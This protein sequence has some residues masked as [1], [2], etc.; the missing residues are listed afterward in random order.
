M[1]ILSKQQEK[2]RLTLIL[3]MRLQKNTLFM[4]FPMSKKVWAHGQSVILP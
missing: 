4:G 2:M 3:E 1:K